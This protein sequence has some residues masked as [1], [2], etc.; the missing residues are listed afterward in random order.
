MSSTDKYIA[1][2]TEKKPDEIFSPVEIEQISY[3]LS[4]QQE[5]EIARRDQ[6]DNWDFPFTSFEYAKP[7]LDFTILEKLRSLGIER[8]YI[9]PDG[10][11]FA[12]CISHDLDHW[13]MN[14]IQ[15]RQRSITKK[16]NTPL[17]K[18]F[19]S[20]ANLTSVAT[21]SNSLWCFEKWLQFEKSLGF[22]ATYFIY[23]NPPDVGN[24]HLYDNLHYLNDTIKFAG[25]K[26]TIAEAV[27]M[28]V[29]EGFEIGLHGS[30]H[31]WKNPDLFAAQKK[32][33]E[34]I[35]GKEITTTRQHYLHYDINTTPAVHTAN[36]IKVDSTLGF[37]RTIGF[38]AGTCM[39]YF[40]QTKNGEEVLEV[41]MIVMDGALFTSNAL[42]LDEELAI[43]K[44][45]H[46]MDLCEE[47]GGVLTINFHP[48]YIT[49][50]TWW[51]TFRAI[52]EEAKRRNA[53]NGS[54]MDIY[55]LVKKQVS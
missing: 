10:K 43:K 27:R 33:L 22:T 49:Q 3:H 30:Y 13:G 25:K 15:S 12:F 23:V 48:N 28:I 34:Q 24:Q 11:K 37:N 32:G 45:F 8:K 31:S 14:K 1:L 54:L 36:S 20:L 18:I 4:H 26:V 9:W 44:S 50:P 52:A 21:P 6:W 29:K 5:K 2:F 40:L 47:A 19:T 35:T 7:Y 55:H 46:M 16:W 53:F 38:R 41:P 42:E 17:H 51:N 39:P